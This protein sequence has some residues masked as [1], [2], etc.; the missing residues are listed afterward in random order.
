MFGTEYSV[1]NFDNLITYKYVYCWPWKSNYDTKYTYMYIYVHVHI[2]S[3]DV[4]IKKIFLI[5]NENKL[6]DVLCFFIMI[7]SKKFTSAFTIVIFFFNIFNSVQNMVIIS[8]ITQ[9]LLL[10]SF[11]CFLF[12]YQNRVIF[13]TVDILIIYQHF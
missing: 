5:N 1:F 3:T 6:E 7:I 8:I 10:L 11:R 2:S 4:F 9:S 13:S 12:K